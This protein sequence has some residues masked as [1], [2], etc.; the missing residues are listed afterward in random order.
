VGPK[1]Q[2]GIFSQISSSPRIVTGQL[3]PADK[4]SSPTFASQESKVQSTTRPQTSRKSLGKENQAPPANKR[5]P[6]PAANKGKI[7]ATEEDKLKS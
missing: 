5:T 6:P 3:K 1:L 7:I 4:P 2:K